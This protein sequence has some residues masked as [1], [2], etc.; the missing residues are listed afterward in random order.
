MSVSLYLYHSPDNPD[1]PDCSRDIHSY[2]NPDN[3]DQ[4]CVYP[5]SIQPGK[6]AVAETGPLKP[7][8]KKKKKKNEE[9]EERKR[10]RG[11][12]LVKRPPITLIVIFLNRN[13]LNKL[14]NLNKHHSL[15][16][17][18]HQPVANQV[19][20]GDL[21]SHGLSFSLWTRVVRVRKNRIS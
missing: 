17:P 13:N 12:S 15:L 19:T 1:N 21:K 16:E 14:N 10:E 7:P 8:L 9:R 11:E 20:Q 4:V 3:F 6:K 18:V 2:D 5:V